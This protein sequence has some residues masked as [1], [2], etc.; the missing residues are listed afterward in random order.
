MTME[1][2]NSW[3]EWYGTYLRIQISERTFLTANVHKNKPVNTAT[4]KHTLIAVLAAMV[5]EE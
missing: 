4:A 5:R 1:S 2:A 3:W